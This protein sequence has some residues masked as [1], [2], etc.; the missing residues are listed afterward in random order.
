MTNPAIHAFE[1]W[2]DVSLCQN[3]LLDTGIYMG[4]IVILS[5]ELSWSDG[6][7]KKETNLS[8]V[9]NFHSRKSSNAE[10][11]RSLSILLRGSML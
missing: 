4:V 10:S 8:R 7:S 6:N 2:K 1:M 11:R 9:S 3:Q 5:Q